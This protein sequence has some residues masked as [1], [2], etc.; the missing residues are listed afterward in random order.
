M[1]LYTGCPN[2]GPFLFILNK[3]KPKVGKLH[4]HKGKITDIHLTTPKNYQQSP[5]KPGCRGKPILRSELN[6]ENQLLMTLMKIRQ[7]LHIE[8]LAFRFGVSAASVNVS[9]IISI[10]IEFLSKELEPLIY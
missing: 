2:Y 5:S 1:K 4:F 6:A 3:V 10:W 9:R 8:D 7:D